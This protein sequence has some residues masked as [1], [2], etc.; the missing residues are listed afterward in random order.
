MVKRKKADDTEPNTNG[1]EYSN[2]K[3]SNLVD[4]FN[5]RSKLQHKL[6][7][8]EEIMSSQ[9]HIGSQVPEEPKHNPP[10]IVITDGM[11]I[12]ICNGCDQAITPEQKIYPN[13]IVFQ[14]K[15]VVGFYHR[16]LN[17]YIH[18]LN[19]VHFHLDMQCLCKKDLSVQMRQFFMYDE[20]FVE[21]SHK[22]LQ[23]LNAKGFLKYVIENINN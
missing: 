1:C 13:N 14:R 6:G 12:Y 8:A 3:S 17:K 5:I 20:V 9:F 10:L 16:I 7:E 23:V 15:K 4:D 21:L 18:K 19:N 11:S 2:S 22:Q